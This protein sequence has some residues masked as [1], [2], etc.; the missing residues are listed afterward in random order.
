MRCADDCCK[1]V[2]DLVK[3]RRVEALVHDVLDGVGTGTFE[4][5]GFPEG[6][7]D[8][9]LSRQAC[10]ELVAHLRTAAA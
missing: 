7:L 1:R 2:M 8:A 9:D 5:I 6:G 3:D 4:G 10:V